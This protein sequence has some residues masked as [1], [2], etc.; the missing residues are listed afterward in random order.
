MNST[1]L[2]VGL[3]CTGVG[4]FN[5]GIESFFRDCFDGLR[6]HLATSGVC[7][8]L[9]KGAGPDVPPDEHRLWC[10]PRTGRAAAFLGQAIRRT[11]HTV[12]QLS[13]VLPLIRRL[14]T[15]RPSTDL[16]FTSEGNLLLALRRV[17]RLSGLT[18]P[19]ILFSNGGPVNPPFP[20]TNHVQQVVPEGLEHALA[21]GEPAEKHSLVPYGLSVPAGEPERLD[22]EER[23]SLRARLGLPV[24]GRPLVLSVGWITRG[25]K[26]M[27]YVVNEVAALPADRR[28]HLVLLGAM[29]AASEDI[30]ALARERLGLAGFTARS[31]APEEV[32]DYYHAADVFTLASLREGFGRVYLEALV[33]GLPCVVHD[34]PTMRYVLGDEGTFADLARPGALTYALSVLLPV[35][36]LT[37][38]AR[39]RRRES[40][41]ARFGWGALAPSYAAMFRR[42]TIPAR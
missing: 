25:H 39:A 21:A 32:A 37:P 28:P 8:Y 10:L 38:P 16:L 2:N 35:P 19:P 20:L 18:L 24:D 26:R 31:V 11:P 22:P 5:R 7:L 34:A 3:V 29:D 23:R 41:R 40:V 42:A 6:P 30:L 17:Q 15:A 12:E 13:S 27:D 14:R 4:V 36:D 1:P 33:A 9:L